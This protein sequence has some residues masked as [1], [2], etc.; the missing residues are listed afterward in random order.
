MNI[1]SLLAFPNIDPIAFSVGGFAVRWYALAYMAGIIGGWKYVAWLDKKSAK[2]LLS[3]NHLDD[4]ILW[5]VIGVILGGRI[6]Y[7]LFYNLPYYAE[8]PFNALKIWQGGMSFHGGALGVILSYYIFSR[9]Y[10][11]PYVELMDRICCAVP[12][13]LFFGRIANFINGE[14]YGRVSDFAFAMIFPHGGALP[15]HPSQL[16]EAALEGAV[17]FLLLWW[18]AVRR[19]MLQKQH[20]GIISGAFLA[21]YGCFRF[22]IEYFREPDAHIGLLFNFISTGQLLCLPMIIIGGWLILRSQFYKINLPQTE[23]KP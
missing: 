7:V 5:A 10:K 14:L 16:Y 13:G 19:K 2:P 15:R 22:I 21:G 18:L 8:N 1:I 11:I 9:K 17:L 23:D 4:M 12:I 6:G 20:A 3:K